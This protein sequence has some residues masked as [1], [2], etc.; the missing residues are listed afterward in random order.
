MKFEIC[1][2]LLKRLHVARDNANL[3]SSKLCSDC[4][5]KKGDTSGEEFKLAVASRKVIHGID[6]AIVGL[7]RNMEEIYPEQTN[8]Y[9]KSLL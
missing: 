9:R 8:E 3:C 6:G 1:L 2:E 7:V 5:D 4:L